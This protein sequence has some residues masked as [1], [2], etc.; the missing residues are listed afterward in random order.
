VRRVLNWDVNATLWAIDQVGK[1][2]VW[3]ET[4]CVS[5]L[6]RM[7][8][9]M[10]GEPVGPPLAYHSLNSAIDVSRELGGVRKVLTD[11]GAVPLDLIAYANTGDVLVDVRRAGDDPFE[12]VLPVITDKFLFTEPDGLVQ[13]LPLH[14]APLEAVP[15]RLP[16]G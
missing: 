7:L 1:P 3:G 14:A 11:L 13:L 12:P 8:A 4:D 10:Y 15:Y 5:L 2:F 9:V 16:H 6:R